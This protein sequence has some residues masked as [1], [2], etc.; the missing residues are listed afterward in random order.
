MNRKMQNWCLA[1]ALV[2]GLTGARMASADILI[3]DDSS[4]VQDSQTGEYQYDVELDPGSSATYMEPGDGFVLYD[5]PGLITTGP[6]V[7][8]LTGLP[9]SISNFVIDQ[10][11]LGNFLNGPTPSNSNTQASFTPNSVDTAAGFEGLHDS[12]NIENLSFVYNGP[13][14]PNISNVTIG[15]LTLWSSDTGPTDTDGD[16]VNASVDHSGAGES[17][18]YIPDNETAPV[19]EPA[20]FGLIAVAGSMLLSRR[21]SHKTP[22]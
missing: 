20:T 11:L 9:F 18:S 17:L 5:W 4:G 15:V 19:P 2:T 16:S 6:N 8:T 14:V 12:P 7:P 22:A 13:N 1:F 3:Y 21:R 10:S